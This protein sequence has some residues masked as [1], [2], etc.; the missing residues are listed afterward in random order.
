[1]AKDAVANSAARVALLR[2]IESFRSL[3][4]SV[5]EKMAELADY[6][7]VLRGEVLIREG[8]PASDL[9]IVLKGRFIVLVGEKPIAEVTMG[10]PIGELAF[11]AGGTRTATVVAARNS[12]V[13]R[14]SRTAY[15]TL[16]R[17]TPELSNGIL[18][19]LSER[20]SQTLSDRPELRPKAGKVCAVFAGGRAPLDPKFVAGLKYAFSRSPDWCVLEETDCPVSPDD[21]ANMAAWLEAQEAQ[22]GN[23]VLLCNAPKGQSAWQQVAAEN[24]DTSLIVLK[25]ASKV[26]EPSELE[27]DLM[28]AT[29]R[30]NIQLVFCRTASSDPTT[31]TAAWLTPRDAAMHHQVA[32]DSVEDFDRLG[33]FVR[34]EALGLVLC[35]GGSLGT[36]HLG[37]IHALQER[38]YAFD[39]IG[40]TS[41]GAAMGAA[42]AI[43]LSPP[44]V[45]DLC[46]DIFIKSRAMS[47]LTIPKH[48]V[49]DHHTL[50]QALAQHYRGYT[51]ED[52]PLNFFSVA[53]SLTHNDTHIIRRGPLW[54]AVRASASIP[55]IFPPFIREDGE[56]LIDGGLLDNVPVTIMRDLKPGPNLI[57]NFIAPKPWRVRAKYQDLPTRA[58]SVSHL[59]SPRKKGQARHPSLMSTL[60]RAMVVNAR[61]LLQQTDIG[62][63]VL[64]NLSTL[65]GMSFMDWKRGRELFDFAY[66]QMS[67][68]MDTPS[69]QTS[70][71]PMDRLRLSAQQIN[72]TGDE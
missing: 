71:N 60:S 63:D 43:G 30:T 42:L 31:G 54:E 32:L 24:S 17:A 15:D 65:K 16:V 45:M 41:V 39:Y 49:L 37:A 4:E 2:N 36:A 21:P 40:G 38:G 7:G 64:L 59:V 29:L 26:Q 5:L 46:E 18:K 57:L 68:A 72:A 20:L 1:M 55:G 23:L 70:P 67:D 48:S 51:V 69:H 13:M 14:L 34:G 61:K 53:T 56:V 19:A 28:N 33:R 22:N 27:H 11:F 35:G 44:D 6:Q 58:Q 3:D 52:T 12:E 8:E 62:S 66:A 10:A 25:R 50:D 9:Y 47:R